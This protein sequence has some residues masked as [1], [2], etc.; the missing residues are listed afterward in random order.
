MSARVGGITESSTLAIDAKAK[1]LKAAGENVIG[2]GAGEPDFPT[3]A[4]IVAAA[5][6]AAS[7][8]LFHHYTPA[9]GLPQLRSAVAAKTKRDSG[10]EV[11]AS[12]VLVANGGKQALYNTFLT[13]LDPGDEVLVP[14]P[15]WVSYPE[16]IKLADGVPVVLPTSEETG[17][18]VTIDQLD[19][20]VTD[21]TKIL[22]FVS[23][24]NPTGAVYQRDRVAE[25]G[26][27]AVERGLWV[28]TDEIYEHLVYGDNQFSSMPVE[29]PE[30][31]ERCI[32]ING[33][34]KTYAMTGWRVGWMI[35][36]QAVIKAAASLQSHTNSNVSNVAQAAALAAV[37][38]GLEAA[39]EMRESFDR[40][41]Q[42][43]HKMLNEIEGVV[44]YEP[45][46]AFYC[47]PNFTGVLG[48]TIRGR[49]VESDLELAAVVLEEAKV[50]FVPG[51]GFGGP[52]YGRLS[53]ATSDDDIVEG[54]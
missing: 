35:G 33:V 34:A 18:Q 15:Y 28:V 2:F 22:L 26:R 52:G 36:P 38:G 54:V 47:F 17:F 12:Q 40:R 43:M 1:A 5:E 44:S 30:L 13:L 11:D 37:E 10:L 21:K 39:F 23:P 51:E 7:K 27:W 45:Q 48:R 41:R 53:Y 50:A 32:V 6:E 9:A 20:A 25:I 16:M 42:T 8:E 31:I 49:R 3:P 19:A 29:V 24:S 4:H 14:A 46:G